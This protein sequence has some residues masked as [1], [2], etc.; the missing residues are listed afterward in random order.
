MTWHDTWQVNVRSASGQ[1]R[2][3]V[4]GPSVND[5]GQRWR[6]A[7]NGG[8]QWSMVAIGGQWWRSTMVTGNGPSL[9]TARPP[10]TTTGPPI[11][12]EK[13]IERQRDLYLAF[14]DLEKTY[15]SVPW[16]LI[17]KT[18]IDKGLSRRYIKPKPICFDHRLV[19]KRDSGGHPMTCGKTMLDMIP[20]GVYRAEFKVE[21]LI[22]KI[23]EG[24]SRWFGHVRKRPQSAPVRR[25][26]ALIVDDLRRRGRPKLRWQD[27][28]KLDM[29]ELLL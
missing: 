8:D 20:N 2:S 7:V 25:V 24:W 4:V 9:T 17:W 19:I 3:T 23:K 12:M 18:L 13:Y 21:T 11:L 10:L 6:S 29:K 5:G 1:R 16:E 28:V 14:I 22:N 15:D 26:E 27:R